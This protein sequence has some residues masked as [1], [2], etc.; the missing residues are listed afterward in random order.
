MASLSGVKRRFAAPIAVIVAVGLLAG[1]G[2]KSEPPT[3]GPV[4]TQTTTG[5]G[6]TSTTDTDT[7][8]P[9]DNGQSDQ[10]FVSQAAISFLSGPNAARVC[11]S[12]ITPAFLKK[13]YGNRS[14][15]IAAR[16]P[17]SLA[18][19]ARL[20]D[21]QIK[22]GT[23]TLSA[24]AKGGVYGKGQKLN[25]GLVRDGT[26]VWRVDTVKSNVPVGP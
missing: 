25:M 19:S 20:S 3:T 4:V 23:A 11:D 22:Q 7:T 18:D 13:A 16:K 12:G 21:I 26:G 15:C 8:A 17:A 24:D 14:G 10:Q 2:E 1:C 9:D 6:T 5:G